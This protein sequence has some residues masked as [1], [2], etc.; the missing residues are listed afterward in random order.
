MWA[1]AL[2]APACIP[3]RTHAPPTPLYPHAQVLIADGYVYL[4]V[5]PTAELDAAGKVWVVWCGVGRVGGWG[6]CNGAHTPTPLR[7]HHACAHTNTHHSHARRHAHTH[8]IMQHPHT[9]T[10]RM[11]IKIAVNIPIMNGQFKYDAELKK[12]VMKKEENPAFISMVR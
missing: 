3:T 6:R 5:R 11:Q 12:K 4:D 7:T 2:T 1:G 8:A 10:P 9:H